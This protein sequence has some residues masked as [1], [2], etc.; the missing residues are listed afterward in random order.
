MPHWLDPCSVSPVLGQNNLQRLSADEQK[1]M[2]VRQK[3]K[4]SSM[5]F[6]FVIC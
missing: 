6:N 2:L 5:F 4:I 3:L 1:L